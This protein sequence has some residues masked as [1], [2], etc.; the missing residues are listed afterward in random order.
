MLS[1][2]LVSIVILNFNGKDYLRKC[3]E[4]VLSSEYPNFEVILV[5]NASTDDSLKNAEALFGSN[6]KIKI[7]KNK[8]NLGFSGGNN[9][10]LKQCSGQYTVFLNNDTTVDPQWLTHLV[11]ALE[12]DPKIGIAQSLICSID[13]EKVQTAGWLYGNY[14]LKK[15]ALFMDKPSRMVYKPKFEVSFVCGAT[16]IV[17]RD[18]LKHMGA[19]DPSIPYFYDDTLLSLKALMAGK[20]VVTVPASKTFHVGGATKVWQTRFTTFHLLKA[21]LAL[22]FDVYYKKTDLAWA[23]LVNTLYL[24]SNLVFVLQK[25]NVPTI[26]GSF[27]AFLWSL[28]NLRY[29][30]RNRLDHWSRTKISPEEL[31]E[32]F[33]RINIPVPFYLFPSKLNNRRFTYSARGLENTAVE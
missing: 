1:A 22:L 2:P 32:K 5:D 9:V 29:L 4:S 6:P 12:N 19:F 23:L 13:G 24:S 10:G 27:D 26:Q 30:W 31:K 17:H 33:V 3:L 25:K 28:G 7:I 18:I 16:M 20:K 21:N 11:E 8:E 14:L 15:Y